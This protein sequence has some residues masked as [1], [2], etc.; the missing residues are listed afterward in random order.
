MNKNIKRILALT[1]ILSVYSVLEP[2]K[3]ISLTNTK[4]QADTTS[5]YLRNLS[6]NKA[7][8][9]F[10]SDS[11]KTNYS[12]NVDD[13]VNE[14][15]ITAR[16]KSDDSEVQI[17]GDMVDSSDNYRKVIDLDDGENV[18]KITVENTDN[19]SKTYTLNITRGNS[20]AGDVYLND[21]S[22]SEGMIDFQKETGSY[23]I[24]LK[25]EMDKI[26]IKAKPEDNNDTIKIDGSIVTEDDGYKQ[27]IELEKGK[28]EIIVEVE[29]KKEKKRSYKLNITR[30]DD[31]NGVEV[32]DNIYLDFIKLSDGA[33]VNISKA[34]T[35]YE[36]QVNED[37]DEIS[38][39]AE[40]ESTKYMVEI[41]GDAVEE[42]EDYTKDDVRLHQ[43]KNEIKVEIEDLNN[44]KR[45]Y[46]LNIYR[47]EIPK[48]ISNNT[49]TETNNSGYPKT[50]QWVQINNKW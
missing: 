13:S 22:L 31:S 1:L 44:K 37:V 14:V 10:D 15:K 3:Y 4:V 35:T 43:G 20:N 48:T 18:I 50:N 26:T 21:I 11:N 9:D 46:T 17:N 23:D 16:P 24:D 41:N 45:T 39:H 8:I 29:N 34:Q 7:D 42:S 38:I 12:V 19:V 40:P 49:S 25:S 30:Q 27:T 47:G 32:Q 36:A 5:I 6:M 28:N 33:E 2:T